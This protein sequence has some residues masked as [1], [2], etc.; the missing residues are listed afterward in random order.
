MGGLWHC[1]NHITPMAMEITIS[2]HHH[3][4]SSWKL[5]QLIEE[6]SQPRPQREPANR[7]EVTQKAWNLDTQNSWFMEN[8]TNLKKKDDTSI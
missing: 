4:D 8:P 3:R 7:T 2:C 6:E 5:Q 1:F